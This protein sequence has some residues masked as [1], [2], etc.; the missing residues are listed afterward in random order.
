MAYMA[1]EVLDLRPPTTRS[2]I[3]SL[4]VLFYQLVVGRIKS[5]AP[6]WEYDIQDPLLRRDIADCISGTPERR[7]GSAQAQFG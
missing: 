7:L 3:Y 5:L 2:D 4:G 6:G 1:P